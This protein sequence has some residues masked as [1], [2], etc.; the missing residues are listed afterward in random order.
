MREAIEV[1]GRDARW[2][3]PK[4]LLFERTNYMATLCGEVMEMVEIVD[5]FKKF[6]GPELKAVTG[7]TIVSPAGFGRLARLASRGMHWWRYLTESTRMLF[8]VL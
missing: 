1:A 6:L 7:D 2:E 5:D 3:F 8:A 4:N